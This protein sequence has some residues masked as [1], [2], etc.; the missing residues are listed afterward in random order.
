MKT[1]VVGLGTQ[2]S[3]TTLLSYLLGN[4]KSSVS[5]FAKEMNIWSP[6]ENKLFR[7]LRYSKE[8][9]DQ[10]NGQKLEK[11]FKNNQNLLK[12]IQKTRT[13]RF[14]FQE[15][16]SKYFLYFKKKLELSNTNLSYDIS[17]SYI[18]LQKDTLKKI[19]DGFKNLNICCKFILVIRD[20]LQRSWS[21]VKQSHKKKLKIPFDVTTFNSNFRQGVDKKLS[22]EDA[23]LKY[24][25]NEYSLYFNNYQNVLEN[26]KSFKPE[27]Y[28]VLFYEE[29]GT[30]IFQS[31]LESFL[32]IKFQDL[33]FKT[34]KNISTSEKLN[35]ALMERTAN[36]YKNTYE[37]CNDQYPNIQKIWKGFKYI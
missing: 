28:L 4:H 35:D 33:D 11:I 2:R 14:N 36:L 5:P 23:F 30:H 15:D 31:S 37:Y 18:G 16:T 27:D 21:S 20:P 34:K 29:L 13:K 12:S 19:Y 26:L 8:N 25:N 1:V 9:I 24:V 3:G 17:P 22:L 10:W 32:K 6:I 7:D